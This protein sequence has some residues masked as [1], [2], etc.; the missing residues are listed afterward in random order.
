M[1]TVERARALLR[2]GRPADTHPLL[3][4][5]H[6]Q[7]RFDALWGI[8]KELVVQAPP[9]ADALCTRALR[10]ARDLAS[11][12]RLLWAL[13]YE[14]ISE[15]NIG[16]SFMMRRASSLATE[17]RAL[18]DS[19]PSAYDLAYA[20]SVEAI[21]A[22]CHGDW[23][24]AE[25]LLR[26]A[27]QAYACLDAATA[28]ERHVLSGFLIGALEAQGK[29]EALRERIAEE[30]VAAL[31]T[32]YRHALA[33]CELSAVGL[34]ELAEDHPLEAI[35][36]ADAL[37]AT[38]APNTGFTPLHFQHFVA[39][40]Q[41]RLYAGHHAQAYQQAEQAWQSIKHTHLAQLDGVAVTV[42]QLRARA[43]LALALHSSPTQAEALRNQALKL[44]AQLARS[45]LTHALAMRHV[46]EAN[47][48]VMCE[49]SSSAE[50]HCLRAAELFDVSDMC[51]LRETARMA[52][53]VVGEGVDAKLDA[54]QSAAFLAQAGV[55]HAAR[56]VAAWF[57]S[58]RSQLLDT[59]LAH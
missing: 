30:R 23:A 26:S 20:G 37:L 11:P 42:H 24:H 22:W 1:S 48:A 43:A 33:S 2:Q 7:Q 28:Q 9:I 46:I 34:L 50:A 29:I 49:Q 27:L 52:R 39:T 36:R 55:H 12:S 51:L 40:T 4:Q 41:A 18:A 8:A 45:P 38:Y 25:Q 16:G 3:D 57:P 14:A 53:G 59:S 58:L 47:V 13:G 19:S 10:E 21:L 15:A 17:V 32:G 35:E 5:T 56:F 6:H 54:G 31:Q 44:A